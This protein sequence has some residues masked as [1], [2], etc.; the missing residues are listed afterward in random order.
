MKIV[1]VYSSFLFLILLTVIIVA[2]MA[3]TRKNVTSS[4]D[5]AVDT[6]PTRDWVTF[7]AAES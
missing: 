4:C 3:A 2:M 1:D 7:W 6:P 5:L